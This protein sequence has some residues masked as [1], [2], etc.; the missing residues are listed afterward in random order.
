MLTELQKLYDVGVVLLDVVRLVAA[1]RLQQTANH[2]VVVEDVL[3][4]IVSDEQP[5][6]NSAAT[7]ALT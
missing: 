3:D 6:H 2:D 7:V 1:V 4:A 5:S